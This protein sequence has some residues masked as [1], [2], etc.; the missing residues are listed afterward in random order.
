MEAEAA[1]HH[2]A[3]ARGPADRRSPSRSSRT[4]LLAAILAVLVAARTSAEA[5]PPDA[6]ARAV[7]AL[8]GGRPEEAV[9]ILEAAILEDPGAL[10]ILELLGKAH[11]Q[12]G[13]QEPAVEVG[14]RVLRAFPERHAT[15]LWL[16]QV[17][18]RGG[19]PAAAIAHYGPLAADRAKLPPALW[20]HAVLG[21]ARSHLAQ[22][23]RSRARQALEP[24]LELSSGEAALL[25]IRSFR[26]EG[27]IQEAIEVARRFQKAIPDGQARLAFLLR[28]RGVE[29][30]R[31]GDGPT[32]LTALR[33]A[34]QLNGSPAVLLDL[35]RVLRAEG[36]RAEAIE[37]FRRVLDRGGPSEPVVAPL[38]QSLLEAGRP[39]E[40]LE[41]ARKT[42]E[43]E[44]EAL[45]AEILLLRALSASGR[46]KELEEECARLARRRG[47]SP[48]RAIP[49]LSTLAY[50][51]QPQIGAAAWVGAAPAPE[52]AALPDTLKLLR[53]AGGHALRE[54]DWNRAARILRKAVELAPGEEELRADLGRSELE[55]GDPARA[56]AAWEPLV[57]SGEAAPA[58]LEGTARAHHAE[59]DLAWALEQIRGTLREAPQ[60]RPAWR[61]Y[62]FLL[63]AAGLEAE[64]EEA[65][66]PAGVPDTDAGG[67]E[68]AAYLLERRRREPPFRMLLDRWQAR[69]P[70]D[71]QVQRALGNALRE[72]ARVARAGWDL[73]E[74]GSRY[75]SL[76]A[77]D[78][79]NHRDRAALAEVLRRQGELVGARKVLDEAGAALETDPYLALEMARLLFAEEKFEPAAERARALL[80]KS[81]PPPIRREASLLEADGFCRSGEPERALRILELLARESPQDERLLLRLYRTAA[82]IG[83]EDQPLRYFEQLE[84]ENPTCPG[85]LSVRITLA[86]AS[87]R[88]GKGVELL[89]RFVVRFPQNHEKWNLL[90][91]VE[92][93]RGEFRAALETFHTAL[94]QD[95]ED[96]KSR[97]GVAAAEIEVGDPAA[98]LLLC[99]EALSRNPWCQ[100]ARSLQV[101]ALA[102]VAGL[103]AALR[104]WEQLRRDFPRDEELFLLK[105]WLL[106]RDGQYKEALA[107]V[108]ELFELAREGGGLPVLLYHGVSAQFEGDSLPAPLFRDQM[109][110]LREA[111][112]TA[113]SLDDLEAWLRNEKPLPPRAVLL[114]FDDARVDN[115]LVADPI[116]EEFGLRAVLF[117]PTGFIREVRTFYLS[118]DDLRR[119]AAT[120]RW[121]I[122]AH[123]HVAHRPLAT[124]FAG[125]PGNFLVS[126]G[127]NPLLQRP[128]SL[129]DMEERVREDH[130]LC[131]EAL[132]REI[133]GRRPRAYAFP[134]GSFGDRE[135]TNEPQAYPLNLCLLRERFR[136]GF[137][138]TK[139]GYNLRDGELLLSRVSVP[140]TG[141]CA[142]LVAHLRETHPA[143]RAR[144]ERAAIL[145][146]SGRYQASLEELD[147]AG[148]EGGSRRAVLL[149]RARSLLWRGDAA[150]AGEAI[151][152][153]LSL[154]PT[155]PRTLEVQRSVD[156]AQGPAL[157]ARFKYSRDREHREVASEI[158]RSELNALPWLR[159]HAEGGHGSYDEPHL[160]LIE[161]TVVE[162]G[163]TAHLREALEVEGAVSENWFGG[164]RDAPGYRAGG[165]FRGL[166]SLYLE[167]E[168]AGGPVQMPRAVAEGI[169]VETQS[170]V[171]AFTPWPGDKLTLSLQGGEYSDGNLRGTAHGELAHR[172]RFL[173]EPELWVGYDG[174]FDD[175]RRR[176]QEYYSPKDLQLHRGF[177]RLEVPV[178]KDFS[179]T[180]RAAGGYGWEEG[181]G[182]PI[183][184]LLLRLRWLIA[185]RLELG[186]EASY[187]QNPGYWETEL[188]A[189][190]LFR[191]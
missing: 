33:E 167:G 88:R 180:A 53:R 10:E 80:E 59:G 108:E 130:R 42:L 72:E 163:A 175:N 140:E 35:A 190:L 116:L 89:R 22:G 41:L 87:E 5:A 174:S 25:S 43:R 168:A 16:A 119:L 155:D 164:A 142:R 126:R 50:L 147:R 183:G 7:L 144:L 3:R 76:V 26:E 109:R 57:R 165:R 112:Y 118:W 114:T 129:L 113:V 149:G 176:V 127:W 51:D 31:I 124:A 28:E 90:G 141:D 189:G 171:A 81:P 106:A 128:E 121:E 97:L 56:L 92:L 136:L 170:L 32:A 99:Q 61:S 131:G 117:V 179:L 152:E 15:R 74:A 36:E 123:G 48:E 178:G 93:E 154:D 2:L 70:R 134:F 4:G 145:S 143:V 12:A 98:G 153:A 47:S 158:G 187:L 102:S 69:F 34:A 52:P 122:E 65:L 146:W 172:L 157:G 13:H 23:E 46:K 66:D 8:E 159:L 75:R 39:E 24:L 30:F 166:D 162:V 79:A 84:A 67:I 1:S 185:S 110:A 68:S 133:D 83:K 101:K 44:P 77:M 20:S 150:A 40:A 94:S 38:G 96:L 148:E 60:D 78:P 188:G 169:R 19:R 156:L 115:L 186:A 139:S 21:L 49:L 62:L 55:A 111:G 173:R 135:V 14:E 64:L 54:A 191:F 104:E 11:L 86:L 17:L 137:Y 58:V 27:R 63:D 9:A 177:V 6:R 151:E 125:G 184:N 73:Q 182:R 29:A 107:E 18:E 132:E 82:E 105:A 138:Q 103:E 85:P 161:A 71:L 100:T 160:K 45:Y 120:G 37:T 95:P 91:E 181:R